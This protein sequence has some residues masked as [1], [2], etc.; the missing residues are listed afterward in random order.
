MIKHLKPWILKGDNKP[1]AAA[2]CRQVLRAPNSD[3]WWL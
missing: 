1:T 2:V 3:V